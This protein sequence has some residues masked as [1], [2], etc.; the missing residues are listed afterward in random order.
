[1]SNGRRRARGRARCTPRGSSGSGLGQARQGDSERPCARA[2]TDLGQF[3]GGLD[4]RLQCPWRC[5]RR[6]RG[7]RCRVTRRRGRGGGLALGGRLGL[8]SGRR[9]RG[10]LGRGGGR[11]ERGDSGLV[12][13]AGSGSLAAAA[14]RPR[15]RQRPDHAGLAFVAHRPESWQATGACGALGRASHHPD[16]ENPPSSLKRPREVVVYIDL[17]TGRWAPCRRPSERPQSPVPTA[18]EEI[19]FKK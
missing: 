5:S 7:G 10:G 4:G 18:L 15:A 16:A 1:V 19:D 11:L 6:G 3:G 17:D 14:M 12:W 13:A 2:E 8:R 9:P